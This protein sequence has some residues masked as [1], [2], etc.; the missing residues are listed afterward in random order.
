M[1]IS[2]V[3]SAGKPSSTN[4][5]L[6]ASVTGAQPVVVKIVAPA[7]VARARARRVPDPDLLDGLLDPPS[8]A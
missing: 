5:P 1:A 8:F 6:T 2:G 4:T 3:G 7:I